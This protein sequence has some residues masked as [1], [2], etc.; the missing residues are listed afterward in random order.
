MDINQ[1]CSSNSHGRA[2]PT[3]TTG[4]DATLTTLN[5]H[6]LSRELGTAVRKKTSEDLGIIVNGKGEG[7]AGHHHSH[8]RHNNT[9]NNNGE[10]TNTTDSGI[11]TV[12][13]R[14]DSRLHP[15]LKEEEEEENSVVRN[16]SP[17][18]ARLPVARTAT[19]TILE[20]KFALEP[21][22]GE[23]TDSDLDIAG[24][25][26]T[27]A[28][29]I[30]SS[31]WPVLSRSS[32]SAPSLS[33]SVDDLASS[34]ESCCLLSPLKLDK[35][36]SE[37]SAASVA[38]SEGA[39]SC[40]LESLPASVKPSRRL[41]FDFYFSFFFSFSGRREE[42]SSSSSNKQQQ[43]QQRQQHQRQQ[44]Q[45]LRELGKAVAFSAVFVL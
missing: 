39:R 32:N 29:A 3:A 9:N 1:D 10:P 41:I 20:D 36:V 34:Q 12:E 6:R 19:T 22:S 27:F 30:E 13:R 4:A 11:V 33:S 2:A 18:H 14:E 44:Q 38:S 43:Q 15:V 35:R 5:C 16:K 21:D 31:S 7:G 37:D 25:G 40:D 8:P 42:D 28:K 26:S 45:Q 23:D 24:L 17:S